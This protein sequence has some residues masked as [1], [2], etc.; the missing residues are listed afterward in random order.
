MLGKLVRRN[1]PHVALVR[2]RGLGPTSSLPSCVAAS[3]RRSNSSKNA[4]VAASNDAREAGQN[5]P[6]PCHPGMPA[7]ALNGQELPLR[8]PIV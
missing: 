6:T 8:R 4:G 7:T 3:G 1:S 2:L 5:R